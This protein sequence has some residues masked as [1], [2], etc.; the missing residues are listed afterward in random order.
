MTVL[1]TTRALVSS[2]INRTIKIQELVV[3]QA[4]T[5]DE[6]TSEIEVIL[7]VINIYHQ[8][9]NSITDL[10]ATM[11]PSARVL[12]R[13]LSR[14]RANPLGTREHASPPRGPPESI[15]VNVSS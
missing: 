9:E 6:D 12:T 1:E 11:L 14:K 2:S 15:I 5:I 4:M 8:N 13:Y 10:S 7:T 3:L